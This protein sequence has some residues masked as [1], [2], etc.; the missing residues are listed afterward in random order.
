MLKRLTASKKEKKKLPSPLQKIIS[1]EKP[2]KNNANTLPIKLC[3][4]FSEPHDFS[5]W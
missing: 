1:Y 2:I 5:V 4:V 3:F